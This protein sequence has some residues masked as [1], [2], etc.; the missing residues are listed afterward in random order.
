MNRTI[1]VVAMLAGLLGGLAFA[2]PPA[3]AE[4]GRNNKMWSYRVH[5]NPMAMSRA[6]IIYQADAARKNGGAGVAGGASG[7]LAGSGASGLAGLPW[8][9]SVANLN[10]VTVSVEG[11]GS[12][13]VRL[14]A[15]QDNVGDVKSTA[16]TAVGD[17]VSIGAI[18]DTAP[19]AGR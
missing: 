13:D 12:A 15:H 4:P 2:A 7:A 8:V 9:R 11:D 19:V 3:A 1:P 10:I 5:G 14:N 18:G 6:T 16:V 17:M